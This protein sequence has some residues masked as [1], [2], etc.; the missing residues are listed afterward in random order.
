MP[1]YFNNYK[2]NVAQDLDS[3]YYKYARPWL[4]P[5][6]FLG[7]VLG[8]VSGAAALGGSAIPGLAPASVATSASLIGLGTVAMGSSLFTSEQYVKWNNSRKIAVEVEKAREAANPAIYVSPLKDNPITGSLFPLIRSY[9]PFTRAY[10]AVADVRDGLE[11]N[12]KGQNSTI[13]SILKLGASQYV[14][15]IKQ[16]NASSASVGSTGKPSNSPAP[17]SYSSLCNSFDKRISWLRSL[18]SNNK[19][20]NQQNGQS[21]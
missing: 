8:C 16:L 17:D 14:S 1:N 9:I 3:F 5:V 18:T 7:G 21:R 10:R 4:R 12:G 20:E 6:M 2:A 13:N 11:T 19:Q 15:N